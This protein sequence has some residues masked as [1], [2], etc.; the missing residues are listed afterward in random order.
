MA[1]SVIGAQGLVNP[2]LSVTT[3]TSGSGTYTTPT[4][5]RYLIVEMVGGGSGGGGGGGNGSNFSTIAG[6]N[7]TAS[8]FGT[9]LLT[10]GGAT[11]G[12]GVGTGGTITVNSPAVNIFSSAG[13]TGFAWQYNFGASTSLPQTAGAASPFGFSPSSA[14]YGQG[15]SGG[16]LS[17]S[18]NGFTGNGGG[19]GGYIKVAL[20]SPAATYAY[21]V[22]TGGAGGTHLG[23]NN[24]DGFAGGGGIIIVTAYF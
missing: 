16:G 2:A 22:G 3:Y 13:G 18:G 9:S 20:V 24:G 21:T 6:A 17:N 12:G 15:G 14:T 4:G 10:A 7:G 23:T 1:I 19:S 11:N 8:T 5:A